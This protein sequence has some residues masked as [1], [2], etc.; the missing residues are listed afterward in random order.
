VIKVSILSKA[1]YQ[2]DARHLSHIA[3][4][5]PFCPIQMHILRVCSRLILF[6]ECLSNWLYF[7]NA[8][9]H[10]FPN[11]R[12]QPNIAICQYRFVLNAKCLFSILHT[13]V[14]WMS[15]HLRFTRVLRNSIT[16]PPALETI[17]LDSKLEI[18]LKFPAS[19]Q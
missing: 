6:M 4:T 17:Q 14:P 1:A 2:V 9:M 18:N 19:F 13:K 7:P 15:C 8:Q 11:N 12:K 5:T 3:T 10:F 16:R